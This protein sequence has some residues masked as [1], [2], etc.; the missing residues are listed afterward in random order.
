MRPTSMFSKLRGRRSMLVM[1]AGAAILFGACDWPSEA[2]ESAPAMPPAPPPPPAKPVV[3]PA[4]PTR[5]QIVFTAGPVEGLNS[6]TEV[7]SMYSNGTGVRQVTDDDVV[8]YW[9]RWSPDGK[10]FVYDC[11]LRV[12]TISADGGNKKVV[13]GGF[14]REMYPDWSPNGRFVVWGADEPT[15]G[16]NLYRTELATGTTVAIT[17]GNAEKW[18]PTWCKDGLIWTSSFNGPSGP[19]Q[20]L[21]LF[22]AAAGTISQLTNMR[23]LPSEA[24]WS[25]DCKK[26]A[27]T[28]QDSAA[29]NFQN[30]IHILDMATRRTTRLTSSD[31]DH[32][33]PTWSPDMSH[34]AFSGSPT[35]NGPGD[36]YTVSVSN[37][38]NEVN[39][40]NSPKVDDVAPDWGAPQP[41][42]YFER[43]DVNAGETQGSGSLVVKLSAPS[44]QTVTAVVTS[45][46]GNAT[47]GSDYNAVSQTLTFAPGETSK[48]VTLGIIDDSL[49]D[50]SESFNVV[51][52]TVTNATLHDE[53][54]Q[55]RVVI[56]DNDSP[57]P[58]SGGGGGSSG[59][60]PP[61][62]PPPPPGGGH[63]VNGR[64][65]YSADGDLFTADPDG[66][67]VVRLTYDGFSRYETD[68]AWSPDGTKIVFSTYGP[69]Y[70]SGDYNLHL[71][72]RNAD[73]SGEVQITND[74]HSDYGAAWSPDGTAIAFTRDMSSASRGFDIYVMQVD[75]NGVPTGQPVGVVETQYSERTPSWD[76][77]ST[78]LA[79]EQ[80]VTDYEIW[81]VEVA[82]KAATRL[83]DNTWNDA[84]PDWA[85]DGSMIA[86]SADE[87]GDFDLRLLSPNGSGTITDLLTGPE[88][89]MEPSWSPDS[90]RIA[91]VRRSISGGAHQ[92]DIFTVAVDGTDV[93]PV[94]SDPSIREVGPDWGTAPIVP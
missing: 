67:D 25:P 4:V 31:L 56:E 29:G 61:P 54:K 82:T 53:D 43:Q 90:D 6:E 22:D 7:Y 93:Q 18:S 11:G 14:S 59:P 50:P 83:T 1:A 71:F 85:P 91:F 74:P 34:L 94:T 21:F 27:F 33:H 47:A 89:E 57:P 45:S 2:A 66:T 52:S 92:T 62:P 28:A 12:C 9:A 64:I 72:V 16:S 58:S 73:G 23:T 26:V 39:L 40:T 70:S 81:I 30:Q 68:P 55:A 3:L 80:Q 19:D 5:D 60:P 41:N 65:V 38:A 15:G 24:E 88:E 37:P 69:N 77:T 78:H 76:P 63:I 49:F 32:S 35:F 84:Y 86:F 79:F 13:S 46:G 36:I 51:L 8:D 75:P 17:A 48:S 20:E 42:L 87:H 10:Q 44:S